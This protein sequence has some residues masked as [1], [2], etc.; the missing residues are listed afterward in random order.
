MASSVIGPEHLPGQSVKLLSQFPAAQ[1]IRPPE[2]VWL[3]TP[4]NNAPD[5]FRCPLVNTN[6]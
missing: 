2:T 1:N 4:V 5:F 3:L 6:E